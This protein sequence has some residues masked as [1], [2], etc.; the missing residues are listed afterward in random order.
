MQLIG[1]E[2]G[3]RRYNLQA[4]QAGGSRSSLILANNEYALISS[5]NTMTSDGQGVFDC[6]IVGDG[7][8]VAKDLTLHYLDTTAEISSTVEILEAKM[9]DL[10]GEYKMELTPTELDDLTINFS[11]N[12]VESNND[13]I[14][15][16]QVLRGDKIEVTQTYETAHGLNYGLYS[17]VPSIS[18]NP[19]F[20]GNTVASVN[21]SIK[22]TI[23][24]NGYFAVSQEEGGTTIIKK[25]TDEPQNGRV[26]ILEDNVKDLQEG[27]HVADTKLDLIQGLLEVDYTSEENYSIEGSTGYYNT[28]VNIGTTIN[29]S[30]K[31]GGSSN[32][33]QSI[34]IPVETGHKFQI[35]GTGGTSALLWARLD[36]N[37]VLLDKSEQSITATNLII[38]AGQNGYLIVGL[39]KA[40]PYSVKRLADMNSNLIEQLE[41]DRDRRR[42]TEQTSTTVTIQP[43]AFNHWATPIS[44]LTLTL[45]A[46]TEGFANEYMLEFTV[47]GD[48]F[49]LSLPSDVRWLEEPVWEDGYTY[50]VSIQNNLA[51]YA[52]WGAAES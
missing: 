22:V 33:Q 43:N 28:N 30:T 10:Y 3:P 23:S 40:E 49:E 5:D 32:A 4:I 36:T 12:V 9:Q 31:T 47:T 44:S 11:G 21:P 14:L 46:G 24:A 8:T 6:Y 48:D 17:T 18:T 16:V 26:L 7:V 25:E 29:I 45:A 1:N 37:A 15:Y 51:L 38:T 41:E 50:Q 34:L 19:V 2:N 13:K 35:S 52:G 27:E 42:I 20:S 39:L